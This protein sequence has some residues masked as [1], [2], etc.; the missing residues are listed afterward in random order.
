[1]YA[2]CCKQCFNATAVL[3]RFSAS[4]AEKSRESDLSRVR[5]EEKRGK[6]LRSGRERGD[7]G[8]VSR[9]FFLLF[10]IGDMIHSREKESGSASLILGYAIS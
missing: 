6:M 7:Q 3:S 4:L 5:S 10:F 8:L 2:A 9:F 1:M